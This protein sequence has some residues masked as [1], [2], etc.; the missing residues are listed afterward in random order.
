[1]NKKLSIIFRVLTVLALIATLATSWVSAFW[2]GELRG[3]LDPV[4]NVN[5]PMCVSRDAN[6]RESPTG[7]VLGHVS[8]GSMVWFTR[9]DLPFAYVAYYDGS[10][11]LEGS[12]T[13]SALEVCSD[14]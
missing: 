13:A 5:L 10:A 6:I 8:T 14:R 7:Y 3:A 11:W 1:M 12:I 9:L 4:R 2:L